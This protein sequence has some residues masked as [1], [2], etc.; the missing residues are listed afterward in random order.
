MQTG[1]MSGYKTK[2][3]WLR[4]HSG[5]AAISWS[6]KKQA[7]VALSSCEAEYMAA[8]MAVKEAI[9]E[10]NFLEEIGITMTSPVM[11]YSDSQSAMALMRHA[12]HHARM[13]HVAILLHFV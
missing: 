6:S 5:G 11:I 12:K 7:V 9:W 2:R 10:R 3:F 13:K 8:T 1:K 4:L